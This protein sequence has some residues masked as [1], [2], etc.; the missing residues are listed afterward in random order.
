MNLN[1]VYCGDCLDVMRGFPADSVDLIMTSP[2]YA[3]ARKHTYGGVPPDQYVEWF[4]P[5]AEEMKRVL[6][7]SGSFVLNIKEKAVNG[8]RHTYVLE[9]I[10]AMRKELGWRWVEEYI[11]TKTD[12]FPAKWKDRFKDAWERLLHFS[13]SQSFKMNQDDVRVKA[14]FVNGRPNGKPSPSDYATNTPKTGSGLSKNRAS[15]IGKGLAYPSNNLN[16]PTVCEEHALGHSAQYPEYIPTFFVKLFTDAKDVVLDPF[17]GSGTTM[18]AAQSLGRQWV[19]I[20]KDQ[21]SVDLSRDRL[22]KTQPALIPA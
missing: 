1:Q 10:I 5:R 7:P 18:A 12:P 16:G 9:L 19:G 2:P 21:S 20:D 6:K 22:N 15:F 4:L 17:C 8:E 3:D 14:K 13:I 11:W